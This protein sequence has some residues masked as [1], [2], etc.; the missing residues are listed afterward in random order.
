MPL[1]A[2]PAVLGSVNLA[3]CTPSRGTNV[4]QAKQSLGQLNTTA[5][6][7]NRRSLIKTAGIG[8]FVA[9]TQPVAWARTSESPKTN[10]HLKQ[11]VCRG[12]YKKIPLL[13]LADEAKRIGLKSI[14]L[15]TPDEFKELKPTG[16][17]CAMLKGAC[18]IPECLNRTQNHDQVEK[19]LR[20]YIEFA[21]ANGLPNV[22]CFSGNRRGMSDEEGLEN[23]AIGLKRVVGFAEKKNVTICMEL[24]NSKV[25]H[26]DYMAD[27]TS[28]GVKLA[29]K[30]GSPRF[31]LLYDIYH[32]QIMEG[33]VIRTIQ[34]NKDYLAHFHTA[35]VPGRLE[36]DDSQELNYSAIARAIV[37]TGF[38]GYLAHEFTPTPP[39]D[40]I[41]SLEQAFRICDV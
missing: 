23:S 16:L 39:H 17:T 32:M 40:P 34:D 18:T 27:H 1:P 19:R 28:W 41:K 25:N 22:I 21:A 5:T 3:V 12:C 15:L 38:D 8:A 35:G 2:C 7:L 36:I 10:G 33:D 26:K 24:L 14:E 4:K 13:K 31:K 6:R 9:T 30:V 29:K 20:E 11:S 37:A